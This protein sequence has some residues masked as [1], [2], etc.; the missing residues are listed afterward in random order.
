V[1]R[2]Y[3]AVMLDGI[4]DQRVD[5]QREL[6]G[7]WR[8]RREGTLTLLLPSLAFLRLHS[9]SCNARFASQD[10]AETRG[11]P[12]VVSWATRKVEIALRGCRPNC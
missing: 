11:M 1:F 10:V 8:H 3:A 6:L 12:V 4:W 9:L 7:G 2:A 5:E